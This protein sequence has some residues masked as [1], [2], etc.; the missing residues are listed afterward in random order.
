MGASGMARDAVVWILLLMFALV[1]MITA[2]E[3][4]TG[5]AVAA[6]FAPNLLTRPVDPV[7]VANALFGGQTP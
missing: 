6:L 5:A 4:T 7:Q 2:Y 3:G 1:L